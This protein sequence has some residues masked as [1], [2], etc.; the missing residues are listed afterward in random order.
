MVAL[1]AP[2][3]IQH[4]LEYGVFAVAG[5]IMGW[6]GTVAMAGHL[7]ALN[8][9][10][11]TF[12]VPLGVSGATAVLVGNAVGRGD[13]AEARSAAAAGLLCGVTFMA[14]TAGVMLLAPGALARVYTSDAGVAAVAAALLPVAGVFQVFDGMQVVSIGILRG[15]GDTR[16]PMLVNILGFWLV[17]LPVSWVLGLHAGLG[18][19]GVWWGLTSGLV[20]VAVFLVLRVRARLAGQVRRV[21]IDG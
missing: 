1:G 21:V 10:S 18:P 6:I 5:L 19:E 7:V 8:L 17:G 9:A 14:L 4:Q 20:V 13:A 15:A 11:L 16:T 3:G 2:I 12:M